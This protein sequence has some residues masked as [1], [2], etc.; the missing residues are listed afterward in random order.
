MGH[1]LHAEELIMQKLRSTLLW[2]LLAISVLT[3]LSMQ[4]LHAAEGQVV[5]ED[6]TPSQL[7]REIK[8][9]ETEF[10]RVFN[11]S[12][13]D[14]N[15]AIICYKHTPTGSNIREELCEPQFLI[16]K[17]GANVNDQRFGNDVLLTPQ[18]LRTALATEYAELTAAMTKL[19]NE[20]EY[21]RELS[22]ILSALREEL[23]SR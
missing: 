18:D 10:Y 16:D 9:I 23:E 12:I 6:L 2:P 13:E 19:S 3:S 17:R 22:G 4:Q 7:R 5:I 15:L 11:L 21:F 14:E 8:K 1:A 20:S